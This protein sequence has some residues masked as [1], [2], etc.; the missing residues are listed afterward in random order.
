ME[1][2]FKGTK[3]WYLSEE[4]SSICSTEVDKRILHPKYKDLKNINGEIAQCWQDHYDEEII[5]PEECEANARMMAN[6]L[7]MFETLVRIKQ[8]LSENSDVLAPFPTRSEID[9]INEVL[10]KSVK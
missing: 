1:L 4:W 8:Y 5:S 10:R 2:N 9:N 7:N 3:G 6:A